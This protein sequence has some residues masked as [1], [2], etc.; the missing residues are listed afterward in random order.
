[1]KKF[2]AKTIPELRRLKGI[3]ISDIKKVMS[4][5][6]YYNW[7]SWEAIPKDETIKTFCKLFEID[8]KTFNKLLKN[9]LKL[10]K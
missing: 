10:K 1:M 2:A 6:T 5:Q 9:T 3:N 8:Q 4:K 7:I